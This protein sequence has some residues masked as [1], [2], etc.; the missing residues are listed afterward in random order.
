MFCHLLYKICIYLF[1]RYI[2]DGEKEGMEKKILKHG[3]MR[4]I[5]FISMIGY[6]N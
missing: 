6:E 1:E 3:K 5:Q 4:L 2:K